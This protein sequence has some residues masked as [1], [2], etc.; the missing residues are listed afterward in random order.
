M[1][2]TIPGSSL[3]GETSETV[4]Y[5]EIGDNEFVIRDDESRIA[6]YKAAFDDVLAQTL[7]PSETAL[8]I[9][10]TRHRLEVQPRSS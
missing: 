5:R 4:V 3:T 6:Q 10:E 2:M 8:R 1:I 9:K 7:S